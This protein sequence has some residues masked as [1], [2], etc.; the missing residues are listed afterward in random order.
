[1]R[2]GDTLTEA[3]QLNF[4]G[5]PYFAPEILRRVRLDDPIKAKKLRQAL[6]N[7]PRKAWC[8]VPSAR[9]RAPLVGVVGTLQLDVLAARLGAEYGIAI[10]FDATPFS[11][12]RW[13]SSDE[14]AA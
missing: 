13:V 12:A 8:T 2:I 11:L 9:W 1:M 5:V 3:G 10:G 6:A 7:W 4:I 14:P